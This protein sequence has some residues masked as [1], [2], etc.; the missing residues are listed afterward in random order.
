M[1]MVAM[2]LAGLFVMGAAMPAA[3]SVSVSVSFGE[4]LSPFGDWVDSGRYGRV[5]APRHVEHGWR[6]YTRGHWAYTDDDWTWVSDEDWGWATDHYGRWFFDPSEGWVWVPG[7]EWAP[8]WVV[9]RRGGGY[10]GW[11]PLPPDVDVF[12]GDSD[13]RVDSFAYCFVEER[14]MMDRAVYRSFVA[15]ARNVT[16]IDVTRNVTRYARVNERIVNRGIDVRV[17]EGFTGH[18]VTRSHIREA[19]SPVEARGSR[20]QRGQVAFFR[21]TLAAAATVS[22]VPTP[23]RGRPVERPEQ[24]VRRQEQERQKLQSAELKE[25]A[26]LRQVQEREV[27]HPPVVIQE[28]PEQRPSGRQRPPTIEPPQ[29]HARHEAEQKAQAEHEQREQQ[30]LRERHERETRAVAARA[31]QPQPRPEPPVN[32]H[33]KQDKEKNKPGSR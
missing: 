1:L 15:P 6:P 3:A 21:P 29:L 5:W 20:D 12:Q 16:Y 33:R 30:A 25:R 4:S 8:A 31:Q 10:V 14:R 27:R 23:E 2:V 26:R 13:P 24:V 7:D 22:S 32:A 11:A 28:A 9:W 17:V 19:A 18:A